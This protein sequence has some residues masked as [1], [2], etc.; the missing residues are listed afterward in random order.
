LSLVSGY[1]TFL[2]FDSNRFLSASKCTLLFLSLR[3][4]FCAS[5]YSLRSHPTSCCFFL[6]CLRNGNIGC[7]SIQPFFASQVLESKSFVDRRGCCGCTSCLYCISRS[8]LLSLF[9]AGMMN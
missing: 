2:I 7:L 1:T 4:L 5:T 8:T 3:V 9:A 6:P